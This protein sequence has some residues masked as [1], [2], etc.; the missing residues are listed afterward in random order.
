MDETVLKVDHRPIK[1]L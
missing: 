1:R